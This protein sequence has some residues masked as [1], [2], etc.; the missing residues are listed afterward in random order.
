MTTTALMWRKVTARLPSLC[1]RGCDVPP[2]FD[3]VVAKSLA[4]ERSERFATAGDF[5]DALTEAWANSN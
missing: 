2:E 5:V 1:G 3:K 4:R